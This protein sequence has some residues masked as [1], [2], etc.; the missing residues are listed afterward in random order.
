MARGTVRGDALL[1]PSVEHQRFVTVSAP[2]HAVETLGSMTRRSVLGGVEEYER[3]PNGGS[4][5]TIFPFGRPG[6]HLRF[7]DG[8][9]GCQG[10]LTTEPE[11]M[12]RALGFKQILHFTKGKYI[13]F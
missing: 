1:G 11:D 2:Q 9:G 12:V 6:P 7:E 8:W 13:Q 4:Q 5:A 10:G 3:R